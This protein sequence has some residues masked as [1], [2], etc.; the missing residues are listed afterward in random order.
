MN[1]VVCDNTCLA[2]ADG[3]ED[4][5]AWWSDN[6]AAN[7]ITCA[8]DTASPINPGCIAG[9]A[10]TFFEDY[11]AGDLRPII[12]GALFNKGTLPVSVPTVDLAGRPRVVERIDIGAYEAAQS[13][14][15]IMLK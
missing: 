9:T 5:N 8:F 11:G 2:P 15:L 6:T 13:A 12:Q 10:E 3:Y 7:F 1:C 14:S 4:C